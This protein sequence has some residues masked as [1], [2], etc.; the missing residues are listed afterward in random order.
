M[1]EPESDAGGRGAGALRTMLF[2]GVIFAGS[3]LLFIV[4]PMIARMALPLL[5]GAPNVWNSAMLVFQFLL[6]GG[7]AY[8]H[9]LSRLSLRWQLAVHLGLLA[10]STLMLPVALAGL[11]T[12]RSGWEI[13]WVP[14]LFFASIGPVFLLLSSHASLL[15]NW[16]AMGAGSGNP[17]RLYVASNLGSFAGL[18]AYPFWIEQS[19]SLGAQSGLWSAGYL[20]V[21]GAVALIGLALFRAGNGRRVAQD[22]GAI[23][24]SHEGEGTAPRER[25]APAR[26]AM[27]LALAAVPSGLMLST[28]TLLTTDLM[29]M[30][31]LWVIPLGL[32]L[33]SFTIAFSD[34]GLWT[35]ILSG[36][37]PFLLLI[38]GGFAMISGGQSN[39]AIALMMVALLFVLSVALHGR[40]YHLRPEPAR[41]TL[42]YLA[43]AAGGAMGGLFTALIAPV[44]F[45]WVYEHGLLLLAAAL[46]IPHRQFIAPLRRLQEAARGRGLIWGGLVL[47]G[48]A[49]IGGVLAW[50]LSEATVT[51]QGEQILLF[52]SVLIV[53]GIVLIGW[54]GAYAAVLACLMLGF[55]GLATLETSLSGDR[56]RSY[57]GIY[58]VVPVE[59]GQIRRLVH[60]TTM[61][62]QQW[63]D[64]AKRDEPTGYYGRSSGVGLVLEEAAEDA[65]VGIVGLGVGTLACYRQPGQRWSFFE[66]DPAVIGYSRDGT[67]T[68]LRDC[69]PD[70]RIVIGDARLELVDEP[71]GAFDILAVDAFT[72]DAIP[73]HLLTREAFAVY[74]RAM[75]EDGVL[76]LHVSNRYF[77]LP[78]MVV[79]LAEEQGWHG[80]TR[81]DEVEDVPGQS[82]SNWIVLSPS[83]ERI[84]ALAARDGGLW[85]ALPPPAK[86]V[87]TD[88][89][90]SLIQLL[91]F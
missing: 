73:V 86:S 84:E 52:A 14:A 70:A 13:L 5:G 59:N 83:M 55:G 37:A 36:Y 87:W 20:A 35:G 19:F 82:P 88:S 24:A 23:E 12:A 77:N 49:L 44:L 40:L 8:A 42:F 72:S 78:P 46:L 38:V 21:I 43:V 74:S 91:D 62:G 26:L 32:Y 61:H 68:F 16:F 50:A 25:I 66:I 64:P 85:T 79:A 2:A 31:L 47:A 30:P 11:P 29:A 4:Q 22:A 53:L 3:F 69:A 60:G 67:F 10:L 54:R 63:L 71:A 6:L 39:P 48:A 90:A 9:G 45:D 17:Y 81:F 34:Q 65:R 51:G 80:L 41:L 33:L 76:V 57:F 28:T 15:Q 7:Y 75:A 27:W 89:N 56:L 1:I 18:L 58:S